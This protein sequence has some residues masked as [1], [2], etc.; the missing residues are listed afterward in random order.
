ML[1][2]TIF[3]KLFFKL[4]K[5]E[6]FLQLQVTIPSAHPVQISRRSDYSYHSVIMWYHTKKLKKRPQVSKRGLVTTAQPKPNFSGTYG[7]REVLG[8]NE[9]SLNAKFYQNR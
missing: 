9:D 8:I 3:Q 1:K 2:K 6:T 5:L 4:K 7:F